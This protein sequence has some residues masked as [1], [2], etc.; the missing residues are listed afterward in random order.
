MQTQARRNLN[1]K[2]LR[3]LAP[4]FYLLATLLLLGVAVAQA[5]GSAGTARQAAGVE[6]VTD[7]AEP[8]LLPFVY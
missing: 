6:A 3:F 8:P 7:H 5:S 1:G 2:P 4:T